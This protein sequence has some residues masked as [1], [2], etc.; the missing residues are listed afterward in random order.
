MFHH[1]L[2]LLFPKL[3]IGCNR[4]LLKNEDAICSSCVYDLPRTHYHLQKDNPLE[5]VFW[6]RTPI[7]KAFSFLYF[8]KGNITQHILHELKYKGNKELGALIGRMYAAE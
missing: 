1:L 2:G 3:C 8:K 7:E 5:K 4:S 6:G